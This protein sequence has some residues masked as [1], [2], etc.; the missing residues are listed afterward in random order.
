MKRLAGAIAAAY[1]ALMGTNYVVHGLLLFDDYLT[2]PETFR[3]VEEIQERIWIYC[4]GQAL[5]AAAFAFIYAKGVD[6]VHSW[7]LQG[8]RYSIVAAFFTVIP[9]S[10]TQYVL[11]HVPYMLAIKWMIAGSLQILIMGLIVAAI[12]R[13]PL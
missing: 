6:E 1:I 4:L 3:S 7:V 10:L 2:Y 11:C 13:E 5:F 12:C 9:Y 8:F